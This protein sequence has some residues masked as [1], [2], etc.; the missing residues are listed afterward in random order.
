MKKPSVGV[1]VLAIMRY[2]SFESLILVRDGAKGA[3]SGLW[4]F[5]KV[6]GVPCRHD[7]VLAIR[8]SRAICADTKQWP[9]IWT[10]VFVIVFVRVSRFRGLVWSGCLP[11]LVL[12]SG[13]GNLVF[14]SS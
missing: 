6:V 2:D 12:D 10:Q 8:C 1:S 5:I 13:L 9:A 14:L 11:E 3:W 7:R 4:L